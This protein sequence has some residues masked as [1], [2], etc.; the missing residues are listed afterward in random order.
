MAR[1]VLTA[2]LQ[3]QA[4]NNVSQVVSQIQSQLNGINVNVQVQGSARA[5]QQIQQ[6]TQ[7]TNQATSAADRMGRAFAVSIRR[8]AAFSI[9]TRAVGLFTS[10][11]SDAIQTSIDFERQLIKISQVTGKS[12]GGLRDLTSE[13]TNLATGLGVS[14]QS[15]L[16][17]TTILTQAGLSAS[18]TKI[19]L[20]S[21]AQAALAPNFDS[22]T[23]TAEGA[24]AILAQFQQGVGALEGQL[25]SINAVAGAFAVEASD[26]IDVIRRTGG[27]FKSSGGDLNELLALFTSVRATTR[28]SAESIG[29]GLRTIFTRIQRPETIEF[30]K[31]FGVNLLDLEGKFVGPFEAVQRLSSALSGLGERDITFIKIAEELGGFRQ[32][33]K[34]LPLLQQFSTAQAALNVATNA[35]NSLSQDA[36]SAQAAL[37]IRITKVREEFLALIRSVT[38]TSTFQVMAN[39]ALT[40][41]SALIKIA[42]SIKPLLPLLAAVAAFRAIRGIGTFVGATTAGLQSGRTFNK[43][44]KVHHFATGGLVPGV[45]NRDTVPAML[46]PGEFVIRKSS[47]QKLGASNLAG[48]NNGGHVGRYAAGG[49]VVGGRNLYGSIGPAQLKSRAID[50]A[51]GPK[52][53]RALSAAQK[54]ELKNKIA[55]DMAEGKRAKGEEDKTGTVKSIEINRVFG[56]SFLRGGAGVNFEGLLSEVLSKGNKTGAKNLTKAITQSTKKSLSESVTKG[57]GV[58]VSAPNA[59]PTFLQ[60]KGSQIFDEEISYMLPQAF[61]KAAKTFNGELGVAGAARPLKSL[62]SQSAIN[63]IEGQFF[64]AFVRSV[65]NNVIA[66]EGKNDAIFDFRSINEEQANKLFGTRKFVLPNEFKNEPNQLNI[67]KTLAKA[68]SEGT[69]YIKV[70]KFAM[71]GRAKGIQGAPLVDDILQTSGSILPRP[72][73]AIQDLIK[74]GGGAVDVDRTLLR[75]IGDKAYGKAPTS[76]A[77]DAALN[78]YFRDQKNRLQDLKTA[79]ITQFG[80]ELQV[81]IKSGK[82]DARKISIASKSQNVRGAREYLSQLFGIP[83]QNIAF[84]QGGD[85]GPFLDAVRKKG[86]RVD[87]VSRFATGGGVG[88]DTIPALLTPGEFVVNRS[89][90]QRIGYGNLNRMN[91]VG[92]YANGGVVQKFLSGTG[93]TGAQPVTMGSGSSSSAGIIR[94]DETQRMMNEL[95]TLSRRMVIERKRIE[96]D[97]IKNIRDAYIKAYNDIKITTDKQVQDAKDAGASAAEISEIFKNANDKV[98]SLKSDTNAQAQVVKERISETKSNTPGALFAKAVSNAKQGGGIDLKSDVG[99]KTFQSLTVAQL[100]HIRSIELASI[101]SGKSAAADTAEAAASNAA[102]RADSQ[103]ASNSTRASANSNN[104]GMGLAIVTGSLSAMLPPLDENSGLLMNMAHGLL[105]LGTTL[106][107]VIFALEAMGVSLT[108]S[109]AASAVGSFLMGTAGTAAATAT[110]ALAISAAQAAVS[111]GA[112]GLG[113][114]ILAL[115]Q[116]IAPTVSAVVNFAGPFLAGVAAVYLFNKAVMGAADAIFGNATKAKEGAIKSGNVE[117]AEKYARRES[118]RQSFSAGGGVGGVAGAA[119]GAYALGGVG[120]AIGTAIVPVIGTAIGG[121]IGSVIGGIG[122]Y[123]AGG[124][125]GNL[126]GGQYEEEAANFAMA[127]AAASKSALE[128]SSAERAATTAMEEFRNGTKSAVDVLDVF[129]ATAAAE[130]IRREQTDKVVKQSTEGRSTGF[131][132]AGRNIATL[133]GGGLF[134]MEWAGTRNARLSKEGVEASRTQREQETKFFDTTSEARNNAIRSVIARGGSKDD[135]KKVV[136]EKLGFDVDEMNKRADNLKVKAESARESG[137][138]ALAAEL[139]VQSRALSDQARQLASSFDN[140]DKA[141]AEAKSSFEAMNLGLRSAT[142]TATAQSASMTRFAAGLE[143]GGSTFNS[144]VAFLQEAIS[145][146]AQA[147]DPA[148]IKQAVDNIGTTLSEYGVAPSDIAKFKGNTS[149]FIQA[150]ANYAGVFSKVRESLLAEGGAK[151]SPKE[152]QNRFADELSGSLV[153]V[154]DDVKNNLKA[155][156]RDMK[157]TDEEVDRLISNKDLSVFGDKLSE[158]EKKMLEP[159]QKFGQELQKAEQVIIDTTKKRI[160]AERNLLE[161]QK[162]AL[163]L[164]LEGRELQG[165]YGGKVVTNAERKQNVLDRANVNGININ[166]PG[167]LPNIRSGSLDEIR[168]RNESIRARFDTIEDRRS[169]RGGME[170]VAGVVRDEKQKDLQQAYKDQI[171][172]IREL[173]KLEEENLKIISEKNKL[174]KDSIDALVNGD[175][176]KFMQ[177]QA[178]IG[179]TAAIATGNQSLMNSF[180]ADALGAAAQDIRRQQEAGV[181]SLYGMQLSGQGGLT[182]QAYSA[183]LSSRGVT[184]PRLAQMAAGTTGEE[185]ASKSRLRDY[186]TALD[187]TGKLGI[188][189]AEMQLNTATI[190]VS[191]AQISMNDIKNRG[192]AVAAIG[193]ANGGL[194]YANRGMFIPRGTD[195]VPAM[196]TPGEFVVRREAVN[197]GNNLQLLKQMNSSG[198]GMTGNSTVMGFA[199][200]GR[201][202]YYAN[203]GVSNNGSYN[204]FLPESFDKLIAT[205]GNVMT[206]VKEVSKAVQSLPTTISHTIGDTKVDVNL[207]GGNVLGEF[208]KTL[209]SEVMSDVSRQLSNSSIGNNGKVTNIGSVL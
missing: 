11:L 111:V 90:A 67:S 178:T 96:E 177:T 161:A 156:I 20:N 208:A 55:K 10:T 171:V 51:G 81:A 186:G 188:Q 189:M 46:S 194:I 29:T 141:V 25:G 70:N 152:L 42:D 166:N 63:S 32:I 143:V 105:T 121:A 155:V 181:G 79:P 71:G 149:A 139:E 192:N 132:A 182:Q 52:N 41:A 23:Q 118:M 184:D 2:Q 6:I 116:A 65:T 196:L 129:S 82:L 12:V 107:G 173:I 27:V 138:F 115:G 187:E 74:A 123:L 102:S 108:V 58:K 61:E 1:F 157:L 87:R 151:L 164:T 193:R 175:I 8:F 33:G 172:T 95:K 14:S 16:E 126:L 168:A 64:E 131:S 169:Q 114:N 78:K 204:G 159:V 130:N 34:V 17:V 28:E 3:L 180:G 198:G 68:A 183:A 89:S 45:G 91:K 75:T 72:T 117:D 9:A 148:E 19:A 7:S 56:A 160:D 40:L 167:G 85:K 37:A 5:Q 77:K 135:A 142:A 110:Q 106:G 104:L 125:I 48:M 98:K 122:G 137:D 43:G 35:N 119:A 92:K 30:L 83:T 94:D 153:G 145:S 154:D 62:L 201:V 76:G 44:G 170:R 4:P 21:L 185:E 127:Q 163:S 99:L 50:A 113:K 73:K 15:L 97:N 200:G 84:T 146:A 49:M 190:N 112:M 199:R 93:S 191:N 179:A 195:T 53:Y 203:G 150:Q 202:Q 38:E 134:G 147:M 136:K 39:T 13:I 86:S 88:T 69:R 162:E 176:D 124:G 209:K 57:S 66:D 101:A 31:Q 165:K 22:I 120:A 59:V 109:S 100:K 24:I 128:L 54:E 158:A 18:D 197:R 144:D 174:E 47:V 133:F 26:L 207:M 206:Y 36:A 205:L 80:K 140:I 60:P 103:E